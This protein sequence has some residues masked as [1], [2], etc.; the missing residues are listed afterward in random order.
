MVA[1]NPAAI[2]PTELSIT[3]IMR[4]SIA[5]DDQSIAQH[6]TAVTPVR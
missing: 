5:G 6:K 3:W 2:V 4:Q 1:D